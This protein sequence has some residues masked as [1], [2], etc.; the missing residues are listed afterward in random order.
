M[1][2]YFQILVCLLFTGCNV[3]DNNK[4][5]IQT[6]VAFVQAKFPKIEDIQSAKY[7]YRKISREGEIGLEHIE[8]VGFIEVGSSFYQKIRKEYKWKQT[9]QSVKVIPKFNFSQ[10][11]DMNYSFLFSY[12]F[13]NDGKYISHSSM[14]NIY[15]DAEKKLLYFELEYA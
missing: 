7:Y 14:G 8:F 13:C 9:K 5:K 10:E 4:I 12:E 3:N 11:K 2:L 6:D 1:L 15:L